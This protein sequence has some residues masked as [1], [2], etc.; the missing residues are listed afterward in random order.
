MRAI[1]VPV[2]DRPECVHALETTFGLAHRLGADVI[3]CHIR[4]QRADDEPETKENQWFSTT[5]REEWPTLPETEALAASDGAHTL[6]KKLA[7]A[8]SY[9]LSKKPGAQKAPVALWQERVGTPNYIMPI[10]G[11]AS[12]MIVVSR[13]LSKGGKKAQALMMQALFTGHRPVLIL[14]QQ[15]HPLAGKKVAI[16]WNKGGFEARTLLAVLPLLKQAEDVV[17]ITV[18]RDSK[19]GPNARDMIGYLKHHGI[20]ARHRDVKSNN[21]PSEKLVAAVIDEGS[22]LL[23]CGAYSRN[24]LHEMIFG[25]VTQHLLTKTD[26]PIL[27]MHH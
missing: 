16:G 10:I 27:M 11:P 6:F 5:P 20:S 17:F 12:D 8:H 21:N 22:D 4:A 13:P 24:R 2:A 18:G 23:V 26:M 7:D 3:G 1:L 9:R 25:G 15:Q 19:S 14:P